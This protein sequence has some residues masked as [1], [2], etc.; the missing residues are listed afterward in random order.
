MSLK[1]MARKV[2]SEDD[3]LTDSVGAASTAGDGIDW[4]REFL[5]VEEVQSLFVWLPCSEP[6]T[7]DLAA[8]DPAT[9]R[10][11]HRIINTTDANEYGIRV[12]DDLLT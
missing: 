1:S 11:A 5:P 12:H 4:D 9:D 6:E 7:I 2:R 10:S 3:A 8:T